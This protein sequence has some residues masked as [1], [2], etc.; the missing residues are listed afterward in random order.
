MQIVTS[1]HRFAQCGYLYDFYIIF[2]GKVNILNEIHF[3]SFTSYLVLKSCC[4]IILTIF[5]P[6]TL[7]TPYLLYLGWQCNVRQLRLYRVTTSELDGFKTGPP[8]QSSGLE[9]RGLETGQ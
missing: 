9:I 4:L 1:D 7:K 3:K 5:L 6:N 2:Y 8:I